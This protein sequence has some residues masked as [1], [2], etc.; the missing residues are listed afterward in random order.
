M[1]NSEI[2]H[3]NT[4][5]LLD[6]SYPLIRSLFLQELFMIMTSVTS[7]APLPS[8]TPSISPLPLSNPGPRL[9]LE[10][11]GDTIGELGFDRLGGI[12]SSSLDANR[13]VC[14]PHLFPRSHSY[15]CVTDPNHL[16]SD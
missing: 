14:Y 6:N 9:S 7:N 3:F 15:A 2:E 1:L 12:P 13:K 8:D 10:C 11:D 16:P 5:L 4:T